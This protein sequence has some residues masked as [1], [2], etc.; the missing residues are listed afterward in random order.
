MKC[1]KCDHEDNFIILKKNNNTGLYCKVCQGWQKWLTKNEIWSYK[2]AGVKE[3]NSFEDVIQSRFGKEIKIDGKIA[4]GIGMKI[5]E[6]LAI[7]KDENGWK[8]KNYTLSKYLDIDNKL[9]IKCLDEILDDPGTQDENIELIFIFL[10][11]LIE[12]GEKVF[13]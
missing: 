7:I 8:A 1:K 10:I 11:T 9:V 4:T 6:N 13:E 2:M 12:K 5:S 3:Y